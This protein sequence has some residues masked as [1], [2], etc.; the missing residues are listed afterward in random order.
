[1]KRIVGVDLG[2]S[3]TMIKVKAYPDAIAATASLD[4][5]AVL[6]TQQRMAFAPTL[7]RERGENRWYGYEA[8]QNPVKDSTMYQN[9]KT[10]LRRPDP[11]VRERAI[12]LTE[13][14]FGFLYRSY[15]EKRQYLF[16]M[17]AD[18]SEE[19]TLVSYPTQWDNAQREIMLSAA[20]KAGFLNVKGMDK[21]TASV[22]CILNEE[23]IELIDK[24][25]LQADKPLT[26]LVIDMG[27]GAAELA[28]VRLTLDGGL[29]TEILGTWPP[30]ES[31]NLFV[32][33]QMD[34]KLLEWLEQWLIDSGA[35]RNTAIGIVEEQRSA[36]KHWKKTELSPRLKSG[37]AMDDCEVVSEMCKSREMKLKPFPVL[38]RARFER[39]FKVY[40]ESFITLVNSA[41]QSL[42][43]EA[44]MVILTGGNSQWYWID[45]VL[46][47]VNGRFGNS[48]L[49]QIAGHPER[50]LRMERPE[51]TVSKGL[52][53][54]RLPLEVQKLPAKLP[55]AAQTSPKLN[56]SSKD[57][58]PNRLVGI[59]LGASYSMIFTKDYLN[60]RMSN[61]SRLDCK[62]V[63]FGQQKMASTPTLIREWGKERWYGHD[64][65]QNPVRDSTLYQN[66]IKDLRSAD[67]KARAQAAAL[68]EDFYSF[69]YRSYA[70]QRRFL[71]D[72]VTNSM[73]NEATMVAY[74]ARWDSTQRELVLNA[75]QNAG[76]ANV[77]GMDEAT[78]SVHC[79]LNAKKEILIKNGLMQAGKPLN[80]VVIDMGSD[81]TDLTFVRIALDG[82]LMTEILGT[83]PS[84]E[85]GPVFGGSQMD[86]LLA[87]WLERWL[88]D[89]GVERTQAKNIVTGRRSMIKRWKEFLVASCLAS[90]Q[91]V[92]DCAAISSIS[93]FI[94]M[95][96]KPFPALDRERFER[97]FH[98]YIE[99]F[100]ALVGGAPQAFREVIQ[101][102]IPTGGNSVWYWVDEV[103]S[104]ANVRFG[105]VGLPQI[106]GH[107][108]RIVRMPIPGQ[109]V[110]RGLVYSKLSRDT[111]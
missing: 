62:A 87:G 60:G 69:L 1:M 24:G 56:R 28:F 29:K 43:D 88:E 75:A 102:V 7:I 34:E 73:G 44:Q 3:C 48:G 11:Q 45:E 105:R 41:P 9:F 106:E 99:N 38:N 108:E 53:Y 22:H 54:S 72:T 78:A 96:L 94:G 84:A 82:G 101:L 59:D 19:E 25:L 4:C 30:T 92:D 76:F 27:A 26:A 90:G 32:G 5:K 58:D 104:D 12:A 52:V 14:F 70:E 97:E 42:R 86:E 21:A 50:I 93:P 55:C 10:D 74:P 91:V 33:S 35:N 68:I 103:L 20:R 57:A 13:D 65:E 36:I 77:Q 40:L 111:W 67:P 18:A 110:A 31:M 83:W 100:A 71:F 85:G 37:Q 80:A 63:S 109:T 95:D 98:A 47:G 49:P 107:P 46:L 16:D 66:F 39:D 23:K 81:A 64:A 6:F 51:E 15:A 61:A 8:E 2:T 79:V 17:A 89:S